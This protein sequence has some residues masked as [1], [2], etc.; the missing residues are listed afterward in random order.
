MFMAY[1][2]VRLALSQVSPEINVK[3]HITIQ[4]CAAMNYGI[5]T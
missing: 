4:A 1:C 2:K 3:L 5:K